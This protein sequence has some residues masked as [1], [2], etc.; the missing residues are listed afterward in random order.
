MGNETFPILDL[1][2]WLNLALW[3]KVCK[4]ALASFPGLLGLKQKAYLELIWSNI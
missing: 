4:I 2:P 1:G 3:G